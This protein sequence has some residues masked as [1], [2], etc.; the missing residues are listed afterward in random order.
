MRGVIKNII[1]CWKLNITRK[2]LW[3][4]NLVFSSLAFIA[5]L[6]F[7][8]SQSA[9]G[10]SII[11]ATDDPIWVKYNP[12]EIGLGAF[13]ILM[14]AIGYF[15]QVRTQ[16]SVLDEVK[17]LIQSQSE[18]TKQ[19]QE[20]TKEMMSLVNDQLRSTNGELIKQQQFSR[21]LMEGG[22]IQRFERLEKEHADTKA[23]HGD[24]RKELG[25]LR[26]KYETLAGQLSAL[27]NLPS[28]DRRNTD[29]LEH[30][31]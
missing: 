17:Q 5:S 29:T 7:F 4:L 10:A 11:D 1:V 30:A 6:S 3:K 31:T 14:F 19:A 25:E 23:N 28:H 2:N 18:I 27:L 22:L 21:E 13:V 16:G 20:S 26:G 15:K 9:L 24:C 12:L 8:F